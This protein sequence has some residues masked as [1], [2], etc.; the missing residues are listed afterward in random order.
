[1]SKA[2]IWNRY[3][4]LMFHKCHLSLDRDSD[5]ILQFKVL[6]PTL[7]QAELA[8]LVGQGAKS[9][10]ED[11]RWRKCNSSLPGPPESLAWEFWLLSA[12]QAKGL[13]LSST[14]ASCRT[15]LAGTGSISVYI[16]VCSCFIAGP[17]R[18][19]QR[20]PPPPWAPPR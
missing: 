2:L 10:W 12:L 18:Q 5:H 3:S 6:F 17:G 20:W 8:E 4:V 13:S 16:Q 7:T 15:G 11:N 9:P 14:V 19:H 1:M